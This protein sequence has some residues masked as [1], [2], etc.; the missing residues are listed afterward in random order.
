MRI[1]HESLIPHLCRQHLLA[2]WREGL[3][4]YKIVTG[5]V[6]GGSY[7][8][9]PA[10]REFLQAKAHLWVVLKQLREEMI[11]RGYHP[12]SMPRK[13]YYNMTFIRFCREED[14]RNK[15]QWQSLEKQIEIIKAKGCQCK[16]HDL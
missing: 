10:T 9:H 14:Y 16:V 5:Q 3:G 15:Y 4:C 7:K 12:K 13:P 8:N 1:W 6:D 11:K 2:M